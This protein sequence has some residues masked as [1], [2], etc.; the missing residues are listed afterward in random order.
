[1]SAT[2]AMLAG[3]GKGYLD[4][5]KERREEKRQADIDARAQAEHDAR[6][7]EYR[8]KA[9]DR[10]AVRGI[11][12]ST[13]D[14]VYTPAQTAELG[15]IEAAKDESGQPY[16]SVGKATDGSAYVRPNFTDEKGSEYRPIDIAKNGHSYMGQVSET[17]LSNEK[18]ASLKQ[19]KIRE[20]AMQGN[21][22]AIDSVDTGSKLEK[23]DS[24]RSAALARARDEG[25]M[26][27]LMG[28]HTGVPASELVTRFEAMGKTKFARN[29]DGTPKFAVTPYEV[30]NADG[31]A[32]KKYRVAGELDDGRPFSVDDAEASGRALYTAMSGYKLLDQKVK[33]AKADEREERKINADE[34][35]AKAD[36]DYKAGML[37]I[38]GQNADT[39]ATRANRDSSGSDRLDDGARFELKGAH[40]SAKDAEKTYIDTLKLVKPGEDPATYQAVNRAQQQLSVAKQN[41]LRT[42]IKHGQVTVDELASQTISAA[43]SPDEIFKS[44]NQLLRV[45]G[46]DVADAVGARVMQ[47]DAWRQMS[48]QKGQQAA[49]GQVQGQ[50]KPELT[51]AE[52]AR[53]LTARQATSG[54]MDAATQARAKEANN[55]NWFQFKGMSKAERDEYVAKYG[56]VLQPTRKNWFGINK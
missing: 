39:N 24:E 49:P 2:I 32:A 47:S 25:T 14:A 19:A 27:V 45:A 8:L 44:L 3:L 28:A 46:A 48:S 52:N 29:E 42:K 31:T 11:L 56:D 22:Y 10:N 6:M 54:V 20:L 38:Y 7:D 50:G 53:L 55:L 26:F 1:M 34:S 9:S 33:D 43:Q 15:A 23:A 4:G 17:P 36:A 35:R 41:L 5:S 40:E 18:I 51:P 37:R 16:Y 12:S 13:P 21:P 30:K